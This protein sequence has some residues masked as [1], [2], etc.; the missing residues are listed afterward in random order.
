MPE[1]LP[2]GLQ[3]ILHCW[4]SGLREVGL[5]SNLH[6]FRVA[7][8]PLAI[9]V[10]SGTVALLDEVSWDVIPYAA[11][12]R[13]LPREVMARHGEKECTRVLG[14]FED[15][16]REG[17]FLSSECLPA[18]SPCRDH[19]LVKSL[20]LCVAGSCN[21]T[22]SYC[23]ASGNS[24][25]PAPGVRHSTE[26]SPNPGNGGPQLMSPETAQAAVRF[27]VAG[28][29]PRR[30][31]DIDFF[32]GEPLL[33]LDVIKATSGY[34]A[35]LARNS[36]KDLGLTI[37][38]NA[39]LITP[40]VCDF[41]NEYRVNAVLSI[42]GRPEVHDAVRRFRSGAPSYEECLRGAQLLASTRK[43]VLDP[44]TYVRGT[45]THDNLDFSKDALHLADL[46]FD[47]VSLEPVVCE[48]GH[49]LA[50]TASDVPAILAE[51]ERLAGEYIR[52]A[53]EGRPFRF[54]HFELDLSGGPCAVRRLAGCG[55]GRDYFAIG[56][57]GSIYPCHQFVGKP[58]FVLGDVWRG[59]ANHSLRAIF[60]RAGVESREECRTCWARYMCGGGCHANAYLI[61]GSIDRPYGIGCELQKKRFECAIYVR[62][63]L[64]RPA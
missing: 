34:A 27:L 20:C 40:D 52:R 14:E 37:T 36:G 58:E 55:A 54:F 16:R 19:L 42:D 24:L 61:N 45:Y 22:C 1:L 4:E 15:L 9:D 39:S 60:S 2:V 35:G 18:E 56:P 31:I 33:D 6:L 44:Y 28:S 49:P 3:D 32:G 29:G 13:D 62:A 64:G 23:F 46:G 59:I 50:I 57:D 8:V 11:S 43:S 17:L 63:M 5:D 38:T 48:E 47:C 30:R 21:M 26:A 25:A 51:Y 10:A 7:G 53:R 41:L 12:G